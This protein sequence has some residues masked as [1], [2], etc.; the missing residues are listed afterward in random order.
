MSD[1]IVAISE[2]NF[3][4]IFLVFFHIK[5]PLF[6][7]VGNSLTGFMMIFKSDWYESIWA[8]CDINSNIP[9]IAFATYT[10]GRPVR[11]GHILV[12]LKAR[13][14]HKILFV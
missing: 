9:Y 14:A 8:E 7:Q 13:K 1:I 11:L 2:T 10:K 6:D 4:S 3:R 5:F 12:K